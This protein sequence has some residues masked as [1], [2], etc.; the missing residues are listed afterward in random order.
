MIYVFDGCELNDRLYTIQRAGQTTRLRPKVFQVLLYLI[1]HRDRVI[2]KQELADHVWP[3]QFIA[4]ATLE[5]TVRAVRQVL[6]DSGREQRMIQTL[7]G[8]GY[9]F[10]GLLTSPVEARNGNES[11]D[12]TASS[13]AREEPVREATET[14]SAPVPILS[15]CPAC[16]IENRPQANYCSSCGAVLAEP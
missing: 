15:F 2:S 4:D 16:G 10:I 9:R 11:Q 8:H 5:S 6:G 1:E 13:A 7:S 3:G 12:K 14:V